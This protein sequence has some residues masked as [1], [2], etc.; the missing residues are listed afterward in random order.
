[1]YKYICICKCFLVKVVTLHRLYNNYERYLLCV[2]YFLHVSYI[3]HKPSLFP[4]WCGDKK[5]LYFQKLKVFISF[6][7]LMCSNLLSRQ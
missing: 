4:T 5:K 7:V 1:M 6:Y 2:N 3:A